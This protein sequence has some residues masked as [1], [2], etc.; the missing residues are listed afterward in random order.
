MPRPLLIVNQSDSLI[1][2]VGI[3]QTEQQTVQI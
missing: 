2:I 3:K 1:Q